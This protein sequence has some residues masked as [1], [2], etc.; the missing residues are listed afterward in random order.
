MVKISRGFRKNQQ[1][2][3]S[4][5][6]MRNSFRLDCRAGLI[7]L[8]TARKGSTQ[9]FQLWCFRRC[10]RITLQECINIWRGVGKSYTIPSCDLLANGS[11]LLD[12]KDW[13]RRLENLILVWQ[14]RG[15]TCAFLSTPTF[16]Q[17]R[18]QNTQASPFTNSCT[19]ILNTINLID[20]LRVNI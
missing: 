17:S 6:W 11:K 14:I 3:R 19:K 8:T 10:M 20:T 9:V 15:I 1:K 4:T 18:C 7:A 13:E 5:F 2:Q 12:Q 16:L